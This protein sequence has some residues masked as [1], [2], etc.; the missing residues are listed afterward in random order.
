MP[1][2]FSSVTINMIAKESHAVRGDFKEIGRVFEKEHQ[3]Q[4]TQGGLER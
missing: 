1:K 2:G 3:N 4:P